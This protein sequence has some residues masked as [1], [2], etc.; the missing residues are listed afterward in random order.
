MDLEPLDQL[1]TM[2]RKAKSVPLS[3]SVVIPKQEALSLLTALR[4]S[5]PKEADL[6][7]QIVADRDRVVAEARTEADHILEQ[8]RS[9]RARM[10]SRAE[11]VRAAE[12][13]AARVVSEAEA[14]ATKLR[15]EADDYV[16][17]KL[18]SF[19]ILLSKVSRSV[20]RGREQLRRRLEAH[21]DMVA[22]LELDDSGEISA[23]IPVTNG[24]EQPGPYV[25]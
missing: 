22:P 15:I 14:A 16:D 25:Q 11:V 10:L 13:E 23:E 19:E 2:V 12:A 17:S 4:E 1:E 20:H 24:H 18:A 8:C 3:A 21:Q 6:A 9:E 5:L 7:Q